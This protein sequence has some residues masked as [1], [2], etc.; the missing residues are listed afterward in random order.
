MYKALEAYVRSVNS[1]STWISKVVKFFYLGLL[2]ILI[3]ELITRFVFNEPSHW[4]IESA[5]FVLTTMYIFGG[6]YTL[7]EGRHVRMDAFYN[8]WTAKRKVITDT[9]TSLLAVA[10][11]VV[12]ILAGFN[13]FLYALEVGQVSVSA[14]RVPLAP[15]KIILTVGATLMLLQVI[16][17]VIKNL[18][19][20]KGKT[21]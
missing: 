7:L 11:L 19:K 17:I 6:A 2:V 3:V 15:I 14:W 1:I 16:A 12:F 21:I 8:R 4:T 13:S 10:F 5:L 20:I 9:V 18:L